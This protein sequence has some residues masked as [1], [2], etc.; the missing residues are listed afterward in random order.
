MTCC[1]TDT[2]CVLCVISTR[3]H[4]RTSM[5]KLRCMNP[6]SPSSSTSVCASLNLSRSVAHLGF[7]DEARPSSGAFFTM[8][9]PS[10]FLPYPHVSFVPFPA[11]TIS[12]LALPPFLLPHGKSPPNLAKYIRNTVISPSRIPFGLTSAATALLSYF[13]R[14]NVSYVYSKLVTTQRTGGRGHGPP[15]SL[16]RSANGRSHV[17]TV[18][19]L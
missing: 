15:K 2:S 6:S 7:Y 19:R 12:A 8:F 16:P 11:T 3:P 10:S 18:C 4:G 1:Q 9:L 14:G 5:S 13:E 17:N